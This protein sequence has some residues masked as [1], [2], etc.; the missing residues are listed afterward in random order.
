MGALVGCYDG[1]EILEKVTDNTVEDVTLTIDHTVDAGDS[2]LNVRNVVGRTVNYADADK[3]N[4][5]LAETNTI[6]NV[7]IKYVGIKVDGEEDEAE[8]VPDGETQEGTG[9]ETENDGAQTE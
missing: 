3:A 8:Q 1:A 5:Q 2:A 7:T 6:G 9:E 4:E